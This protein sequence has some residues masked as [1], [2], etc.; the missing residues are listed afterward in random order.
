MATFTPGDWATWVR[1]ERSG[2]GFVS[3]VRVQII[4]TTAKRVRIRALQRDGT[5]VERAVRPEHL[6]AREERA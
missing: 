5:W 4:R 3:P 2:T 6:Q 1:E